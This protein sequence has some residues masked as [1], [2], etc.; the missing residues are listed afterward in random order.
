MK[1]FYIPSGLDL[2]TLVPTRQLSKYYYIIHT[3]YVKKYDDKR[4]SD[5]SENSNGI[6]KDLPKVSK[7]ELKRSYLPLNIKLL[8]KVIHPKYLQTILSNL[9][10]WNIIECDGSYIPGV[11]AKGYRLST[12]YHNMDFRVLGISDIKF[13]NKLNTIE[14]KNMDILTETQLAIYNNMEYFGIDIDKADM[15]L[16]NMDISS[17]EYIS[18]KLSIDRIK[19]RDYFFN[20]DLKTGRV[21]HNYSNMKR[22]L[23]SCLTIGNKTLVEVDIANS[24]PYFLAM[25]LKGDSLDIKLYKELC[26]SGKIYDYLMVLFKRDREYIKKQFLTLLFCK[27]HWDFK[28]KSS[29]IEH[30]PNVYKFIEQQKFDDNSQLA[31]MLQKAEADIMIGVISARLL[32]NDIKFITVHDSVMVSS[33]DIDNTVKIMKECFIETYGDCPF[34][35]SK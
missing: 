31:I 27:N 26:I 4:V 13:A 21:F 12:K 10:E 35:R 9:I 30:F 23:R 32:S 33:D 17:S 7:K 3:L 29:F 8:R 24:Q 19:N 6:Y 11:K 15:L 28:L 14:E 16:D 25:L 34:L 22:E 20:T 5:I 18:I 1:H 2:S